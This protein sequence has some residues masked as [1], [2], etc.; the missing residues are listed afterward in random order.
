MKKALL[1]ISAFIFFLSCSN[2]DTKSDKANI[3]EF[4]ILGSSNEEL[5]IVHQLINKDKSSLYLYFNNDLSTFTFPISFTID[6]ELSNGAKVN[7][8][9][10]NSIEFNDCNDVQTIEIEAEDGTVQEWYVFLVNKQIQ[11]SN[12]ENWYSNKGMNGLYYDEIGLSYE[13][14]VWA[15]AN[16]GTSM[17]EA[18]GTQPIINQDSRY[19]KIQTLNPDELVPLAAGTIYTGRFDVSQA[20]S[21]P[22]D[23]KKATNMGTPFISKPTAFRIKYSYESGDTLCQI[24]FNSSTSIFGGYNKEDLE[25]ED[26]CSI[27]SILENRD[28]DQITE[29]AKAEL[30]SETTSGIIETNIDFNYYS[31][32]NP[33]H[34]IVVFTSSKDGDL[35]KGAVGSKLIVQEFELIYE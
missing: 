12:F 13:K 19:L 3:L 24:T 5:I 20:I 2:D 21:N 27:Y 32:L 4:N 1:M 9:P 16:L 23:P 10:N 34:I 26:Q 28:G 31:D 22:L 7:S 15:T 8:L 30:F 35:W 14:A 25:G 29:I 18:Y 33:T 6:F 11:N 17:Y